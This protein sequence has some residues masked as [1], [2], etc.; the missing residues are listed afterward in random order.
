MPQ[1]D[2]VEQ[3]LVGYPP[4][5]KI[6]VDERPRR[7]GHG[8]V[9]EVPALVNAPVAAPASAP[10]PAPGPGP[11]P[12]LAL[13]PAPAPNS[14][15]GLAL[16]LDPALAPAPHP[17]PQFAPDLGLVPAP[18]PPAF[19]YNPA[20]APVITPA[21][22]DAFF[23][24][25]SQS[26]GYPSAPALAQN[27]NQGG[28]GAVGYPPVAP[29]A[30]HGQPHPYGMYEQAKGN[31]M[32]TDIPMIPPPPNMHDPC[33]M[34]AYEAANSAVFQQGLVKE[35]PVASGSKS[36][37]SSKNGKSGR[38]GKSSE[39]KQEPKKRSKKDGNAN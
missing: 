16:N 9:P 4:L 32:E 34:A 1:A 2:V 24:L 17:V 21:M 33:E 13:A 35:P 39:E 30:M 14:T 37:K 36:S 38:S 26:N 5:A 10:A 27:Y 7:A 19:A 31:V 18:P 11:G 29:Q 3:L 22:M 8:L 15:L 12:A 25:M 23:T 28:Y 20:Q 6:Y